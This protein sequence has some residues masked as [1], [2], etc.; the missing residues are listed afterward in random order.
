MSQYSLSVLCHFVALAGCIISGYVGGQLVITRSI[1]PFF[2][3]QLF[4]WLT[5]RV[6]LIIISH[7]FSLSFSSGV[8]P[9]NLPALSPSSRI[10]ATALSPVTTGPFR[11]F[12]RSRNCVSIS[13]TTSSTVSRPLKSTRPKSGFRRGDSTT[14]QLSRLV[15]QI[16]PLRDTR[17]LVALCFFGLAKAFD[18]VWHRGLLAKLQYSSGVERQALAWLQSYLHNRRQHDC[19]C[20]ARDIRLS[21]SSLWSTARFNFRTSIIYH[22]HEPCTCTG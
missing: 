3:S 10:K 18:I 8:S 14:F 20:G 6:T 4:N 19:C 5:I 21:T 1:L 9:G 22:V 13:C 2:Y 11:S 7:I 17:Q 16:S 15:Q 12:H